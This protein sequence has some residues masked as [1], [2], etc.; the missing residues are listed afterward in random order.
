MSGSITGKEL[1]KAGLKITL[2][3]LRVLEI[4]EDSDERHL[5]AEDVYRKVLDSDASIGLATIYRVL[6]QF[7]SAGILDRHNFDDG[8][9]VY[10]L[11]SI[12]HHDHM[13]DVDSGEVIEF[14]N[15]DIEALQR[16]IAEQH[17][18]D[19]VDH[20]LVLYVRKRA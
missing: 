15:H 4:F 5:S 2:P 11:A 7:E 20:A 3:R 9:A 18:Y 10:E 17:G 13:V 1:Q 16:E 12:D 14:V 8:H 6:T 19:L